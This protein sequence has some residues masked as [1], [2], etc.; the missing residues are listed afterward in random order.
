M[1]RRRV[2]AARRPADEPSFVSLRRP[3]AVVWALNQLSQTEPQAVEQLTSA[4][5][6]L[7]AAQQATLSSSAGGADRLRT[8]TAARR[9]AVSALAETAAGL[10]REAGHGGI[11]VRAAIAGHPTLPIEVGTPLEDREYVYRYE[12]LGKPER[13]FETE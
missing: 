2:P 3:T 13:L 5:A 6:E 11:R 4:G 12:Q 10:L 9:A 7:R 1:G 8:A